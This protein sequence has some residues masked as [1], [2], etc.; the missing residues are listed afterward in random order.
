MP[1][2]PEVETTVRGLQKTIIGKKITDLWSDLPKID[3]IQKETIKNLSYF[4]I[5][6]KKILGTTVKKVE[7]R[8]KNILIH[9]S[10]EETIII[11]L[12]MTGHL[13]YGKYIQKNNTWTPKEDGPLKDPYNRF[14]HVVF[15]FSDKNHLVFCDT[16]K[17]GTV[18]LVSTGES[19]T[20]KLKLLGPEP[21]DKNLTLD[22][23][24]NR[25]N[26]YGNKKIKTALM[27]QEII[28]GIGNIYSDEILWRT[29]INPEKKVVE[30]T[31]KEFSKIYEVMK[32][33][34]SK[35][36]DFGGDSMSDYRNVHGEKGNFQYHHMAYRKTGS[37]CGKNKCTGV[38]LRKVVDGRSAHYCSIHQK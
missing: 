1:E 20:K 11:H 17:F 2:L 14:I 3:H 33:I 16:R 22:I 32:I 4:K 35:G 36:I 34:L 13:L 15:Y 8:A 9:L 12:K 28:S 18:A 23:F 37:K 31:K 26:K 5:F 29:E 38:I 10:N 6:K 27:N 7:R 24:I 21:F 25:F 19:H 30:V